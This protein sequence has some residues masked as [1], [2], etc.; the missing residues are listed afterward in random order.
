ME[1][2]PSVSGTICELNP[3]HRG[4]ALLLS[5]MR[6]CSDLVVCVM[7]GFFV[8]RG[9]PALLSPWARAEMALACG[10]DLVVLLPVSFAVSRA[11][12]FAWGGVRLLSSLGVDTLW[13]GSECGNARQLDQLAEILL[14]PEFSQALRPYLAEGLSFA[15]AR[16]RAVGDLLGETAADLLRGA[17]NTLGT[18]YAK[19]NR[20][21]GHPLSL[22]SVPR[23][24]A[25]H[26]ESLVPDT[27]FQSA[28]HLRQMEQQGQP[29]AP[30]LPEAV[31]AIFAREKERG[32]LCR[33]SS[34][35]PA[36]LSFLRRMQ[37]TDFSNLPECSEGIERRLYHAVRENSTLS[38]VLE[39]AKTK[40]YTM[41]RLRRMALH[42]FLNLSEDCLPPDIPFAFILG[43]SERGLR[44]A[45]Q[46]PFPLVMSHRQMLSLPTG[47]KILLDQE[48]FACDQFSLFQDRPGPCGMFDRHPFVKF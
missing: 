17:N 12:R 8:Q 26:D 10:A 43:I 42:A 31:A 3:L 25:G 24:G 44:Y 13:F 5:R 14:S 1:Q 2:K 33:L 23:K 27:L 15:H 6:A 32:S 47:S 4:H 20:I 38:S 35:E 45:A 48:R 36:I 37:P 21:L 39:H 22:F 9:E 28:S 16:T 40:R 30:F 19:A 11:E 29:I 41:A 46:C 7:S 34:M 18:E